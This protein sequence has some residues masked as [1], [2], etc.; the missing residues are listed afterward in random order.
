M[1][2]A[3]PNLT[4]AA[5]PVLELESRLLE[6]QPA[7]EAWLRRQWAVTTAPFYCSVDLRNAGF[8]LAPVD[9]NLFPAGFNNLSPNFDSLCLQALQVAVERTC[10]TA[11]KLVLV[12]ENH[13]RNRFYMESVARLKGLLQRAGFEVR[14]GSISPEITEPTTLD[15]DSGAQLTLEPL[16]RNADHLHID[17]YF[18]CAVVL[19]NDLSGGVPEI[20]R[21]VAQPLLPPAEVSWAQRLKSQ[22]FAHYREVT[23]EFAEIIDIDPWLMT[24]AFRNCGNINFLK[25]EGEECLAD[26]VET[27][28]AEIQAKYDEYGI[29]KDPFVVIKADAGTYGMGVMTAKHPDELRTLNRNMRKKMASAKGGGEVTGAIIQEGVYTFET[30]GEPPAVAEPVVYMIDHH[31][32]GGFYRVHEGRG[33]DENLNAPGARFHQLAFADPGIAPDASCSPDDTPN[34]FY[35]YGVVARLAMLAAAR[36]I[37]SSV[38]EAA[39]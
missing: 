3:V 21:G 15:L 30:I 16:Q 34:R 10:P 20:L 33:T 5:G 7:I 25:R 36:E 8:K 18:P 2:Q 17:G 26:N 9:T 28:L 37:R 35:A 4:V 11:A 31:V 22:H 23:R 32:V 24:P 13:T 39:A 14:V 38:H 6:A 19:N 12:P 29:D 1:S 27:L